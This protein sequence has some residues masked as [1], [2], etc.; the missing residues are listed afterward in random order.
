[1]ILHIFLQAH[2]AK[3]ILA[4][5]Q[6]AFDIVAA[7]KRAERAQMNSERQKQLRIR[8][9]QDAAAAVAAAA[10]EADV[11]REYSQLR[12]ELRLPETVPDRHMMLS[13]M[14][15][16]IVEMKEQREREQQFRDEQK[17][18]NALRSQQQQEASAAAAAAAA[19][20]R[21]AKKLKPPAPQVTR[22]P[23]ANIAHNTLNPMLCLTRDAAACRCARRCCASVSQ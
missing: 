20:E 2:H 6:R 15:K 22:T 12:Q 17:T 13:S 5:N 9:Q 4:S 1:M 3:S 16:K 18:A 19:A 10:H 23:A 14:E 8:E 7:K 11:R 21:A